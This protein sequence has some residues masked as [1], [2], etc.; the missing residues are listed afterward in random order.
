ME[1]IIELLDNTL[2]KSYSIYSGCKVACVLE[3]NDGSCVCG[4]NIENA[5]YSL[6][7]CAE[8]CAIF[9]AIAQG[10][11]MKNL[12]ALYIKSNKQAFFTPCGACMQVIS[13]FAC[14]ELQVVVYNCEN[15]KKEYKFNE[16]MPVTF[17]L[18]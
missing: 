16:L 12:K 7:I 14:A 15:Q 5:S 8:R 10:Y 1:R 6:A 11:D 9:S 18:N 13:E 2:F 3:F 17:K 4:C